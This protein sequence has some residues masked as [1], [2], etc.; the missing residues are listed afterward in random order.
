[1]VRLTNTP[2]AS[3]TR[4]IERDLGAAEFIETVGV[5]DVRGP[6]ED[7]VTA[8]VAINAPGVTVTTLPDPSFGDWA[9]PDENQ[10]PSDPS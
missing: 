10:A 2:S 4:K 9:L 1:M 6:A 7:A 3:L 8:W 5:L